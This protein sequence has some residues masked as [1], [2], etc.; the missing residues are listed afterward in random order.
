MIDLFTWAGDLKEGREV[1][2]MGTSA[3][4][5]GP[6]LARTRSFSSSI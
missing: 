4:H 6:K 3:H 1:D 2:T 5:S